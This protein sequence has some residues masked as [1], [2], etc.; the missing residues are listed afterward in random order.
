MLEDSHDLDLQIALTSLHKTDPNDRL[1]GWV[2]DD[3]SNT[4]PTLSRGERSQYWLYS[5]ILHL[6][7]LCFMIKTKDPY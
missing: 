7:N 3:I 4:P 6:N 1:L 5:V 2:C